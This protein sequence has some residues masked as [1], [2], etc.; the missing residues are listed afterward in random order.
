MSGARRTID[1]SGLPSVVFGPKSILWW[2]TLGFA[3]IEGFTLVLTVATYLYLRQSSVNWPP[4]RTLDPDVL[5][6]TLNTVLLLLLIWP[7]HRA[8]KAA[9]AFDRAGVARWLS[10]AFLMEI[11][12]VVLRWF[13]LVALHVRWDAHAYASAAWAVVVGHS[14]L[15]L[16]DVAETA[17]F[18]SMFLNGRAERKHYPD[19]PDAA[20]YQYFLSLAWVPLYLIIYWGPRV[21]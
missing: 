17:V 12:V 7:M 21:L 15:L 1:V 14:T 10:I 16:V 9:K 6:P 11:P 5:L 4:G 3:V 13:D 20:D 8:S 2:G 19:V 18:A